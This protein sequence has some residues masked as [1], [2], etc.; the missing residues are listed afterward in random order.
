[1]SIYSQ[2]VLASAF[3]G[4]AI[5]RKAEAERMALQHAVMRAVFCVRTGVLLDTSR[6]VLVTEI[7]TDMS[8]RSWIMT[9][10]AFDAVGRDAVMAAAVKAGNVARVEIIDGRD[11]TQAGKLR[12]T[13]RKARE[14]AATATV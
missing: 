13:A 3:M 12:A 14:A 7:K 1:M 5:D 8:T 11:Y 6:A 10:E 4:D 9:G 2:S